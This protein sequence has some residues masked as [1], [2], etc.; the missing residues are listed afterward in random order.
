MSPDTMLTEADEGKSVITE[1]GDQIGQ[2][3]EVR[4]GDAYV[5]PNPDVTDS[6]KSKLGWGDRQSEETYHLDSTKVVSITDKEVR[7]DM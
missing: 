5:D 7:V 2:V 3:V 6:L 4:N 1:S